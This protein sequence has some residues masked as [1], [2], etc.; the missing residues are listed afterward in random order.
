M[1]SNAD[2]RVATYHLA[3]HLLSSSGDAITI[4]LSRCH[5]I[6]HNSEAHV[7]VVVIA[8]LPT[9][10][11]QGLLLNRSVEASADER[12]MLGR[13]CREA[14]LAPSSIAMSDP[15]DPWGTIAPLRSW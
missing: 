15:A 2:A 9:Y 6:S 5:C 14:C 8:G 7:S 3:V 4:R 1:F 13:L 11:V 10:Y 12:N